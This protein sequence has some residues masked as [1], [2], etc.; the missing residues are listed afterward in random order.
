MVTARLALAPSGAALLAGGTTSYSVPAG[1]SE[2][3]VLKLDDEGTN[4][5]T[6]LLDTNSQPLDESVTIATST[7]GIAPAASTSSEFALT[8]TFALAS[9]GEQCFEETQ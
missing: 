6:F 2:A 5:C 3:W 1:T 4:S 9:P 8:Q 7:V